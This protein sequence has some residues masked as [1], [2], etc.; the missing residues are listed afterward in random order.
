MQ[1]KGARS[2]LS[3]FSVFFFHLK[4]HHSKDVNLKFLLK[5]S[6]RLDIYEGDSYIA[7]AYTLPY[8]LN[9]GYHNNQAYFN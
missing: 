1:F 2:H 8:K 3:N 7:V 6:G 5:R 9:Y 4:N